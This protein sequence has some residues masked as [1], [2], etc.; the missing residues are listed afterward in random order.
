MDLVSK[1]KISSIKRQVELLT[2]ADA[3]N[4]FGRHLWN[5]EPQEA[6]LLLKVSNPHKPQAYL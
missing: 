4:G 5:I 3:F 6:L 2:T 1:L